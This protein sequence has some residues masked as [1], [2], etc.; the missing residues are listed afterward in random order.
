MSYQSG[1]HANQDSDQEKVVKQKY[2]QNNKILLKDTILDT[3]ILQE[4]HNL[5]VIFHKVQLFH[6]NM[7]FKPVIK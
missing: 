5:S 6:R 3:F 7:G 4:G 2:K 1:L